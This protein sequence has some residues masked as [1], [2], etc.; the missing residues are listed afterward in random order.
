M[1][2]MFC[3]YW[4]LGAL[5]VSAGLLFGVDL[6]S[7]GAALE[8]M[9][10]DLGLEDVHDTRS[11]WIV[12]GAKGGAVFGSLF[13]GAF[14]VSRGRRTSIICAAIPF[15]IGPLFVF[16]AQSFWQAFLGR[17]LMGLGFG[18]ASVATPSY[19]S[20]VVPPVHRGLFE[21]MY[22]LGIASGMLISSLLNL[23]LQ[24]L[25]ESGRLGSLGCWRYQAGLVPC[26]FAVPLLLLA[27]MVPESPRWLL[28]TASPSPAKLLASLKEIARLG[29]PGARQRLETVKSLS[30]IVDGLESVQPEHE[31]DE[32]GENEKATSE[33]DLI[34]LW[35]KKHS[36]VGNPLF[37]RE[38]SDCEQVAQ[39]QR[40]LSVLLQTFVDAKD[41]LL[42]KVPSARK[43]L[44]LALSAAVLN[45]A[46]ASTSILIY[47]QKL[48]STVGVQ[49]QTEQDAQSALLI[50][51]KLVG[52]IVGL[53]LVETLTRRALLATGGICSAVALGVIVLGA[54]LSSNEILMVGMGCF[55]LCFFSTWG[56]GYW[57]VVVE[58]TAAGGPRY[59]SAAQ[60][61]AT[62]TLFGTG[63][64]T[65]LTFVQVMSLG[66]L[67]LL[68]Y[69][70]VAVLMFAYG[71]CW[72]P[73]TSGHS[74]EQC[75]HD[76]EVK[77]QGCFVPS[78][79]S[80]TSESSTDVE[81]W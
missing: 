48:L 38:T 2:A 81:K 46:C 52:V 53:F 32:E 13:G 24:A 5:A 78:E 34:V 67:G 45:Q 29:R 71:L 79:D 41:I 56:I 12:S 35:D 31:E 70:C 18:L 28:Q 6:A 37:S 9:S 76:V 77:A 8:G 65:S 54:Q 64:L 15:L 49:T 66:S 55:V 30:N 26:A 27:L 43:G 11:E 80:E 61:M 19:L 25:S 62:A 21:A 42:G 7:I 1:T 4:R 58:V 69:V 36:D 74:L 33:D 68:T 17:L 44:L 59:A 57:A 22:E 47:A 39:K 50:G 51:A 3:M 63:W 20:E 60:A 10:Q 16:A 23:L 40:T 73:E 72:L 14:M 75:A